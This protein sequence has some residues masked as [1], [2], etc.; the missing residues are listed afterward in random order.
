NSGTA[1]INSLLNKS[2]STGT[3]SNSGTADI[4]SLLNKSGSTGTGSNSGTADINSLLGNNTGTGTGVG[5]G[6]GIGIGG[7][8]NFSSGLNGKPTNNNGSASSDTEPTTGG[9]FDE[10]PKP[11]DSLPSFGNPSTGGSFPSFGNPGTGGS[12]GL[13]VPGADS[14]SD[15]FFG[16]TPGSY[17]ELDD[18][19][20]TGSARAAHASANKMMI[21]PLG[22]AQ[23]SVGG[24]GLS[25]I[26][27]AGAGQV[28]S[29]GAAGAFGPAGG[30]P[31]MM[32]PMG[33]M[34]G[35]QQAKERERTT[36]LAE[37]EEVWG[38]DPDV[39]PGVIGR[40]EIPEPVVG[41]SPWSPTTQQ[42]AGSPYGRSS[43]QPVRRTN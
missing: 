1:D 39:A 31:P 42:T 19:S 28:G 20:G 34:G 32:P 40:D 10:A 16:D 22:S 41:S 29:N 5:S 11:V 21:G 2:G 6:I 43:G 4:N 33:G 7:L 15:D 36:W 14:S 9:E 35:N 26:P 38:T 12:P 8:P 25:L 27:V 18:I 30:Y 17:T 13:G 3:G 24:S 37:E 23:A